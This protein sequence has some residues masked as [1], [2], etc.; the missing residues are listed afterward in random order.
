MTKVMPRGAPLLET[1]AGTDN[2]RIGL[3]VGAVAFGFFLAGGVLA[4]LMR[5][6]LAQPGLQVVS[7]SSYNALFTMHGSTMIYLFVTP[8][9]LAM[10]LYLVPLQVGASGVAGPRWA[11]AGMWLLV[12]GGITMWSGWLVQGGAA[13]ATWVGFD[14]LSDAVHSPGKAMDSWIWGVVLATLGELLMAA[15]ILATLLGRRAAGMTMLRMPVFCWA[16]LVTCLMVLFAFPVLIGVMIALW[17]DRQWGGV[18][19]SPGGPVTYQHL[20]WF[21]GHPVVYVMFFPFLG[22]VAEVIAVFSGRRIFGY[23]GIVISLLVFASLSMSVWAHHMFTVQGVTVKYFSLTS[24]LLVVP[25]GM[26]YFS[27]LGTLRGGAIRLTVPMLFALAFLLQFLVGGLSG[28]WVASPALDFHANNSY[29]VVAHFHYTLLAGSIFGFFAGVYYW[30][31]KVTGRLLGERL[32]RVHLAL[33]AIATNLTFAPQFALGEEGMTRRIA[34]YPRAAGWETLN[35]LSTLGS[36]LIAVSVLVFL[37]N[38]AV[39]RRLAGPDPWG[40]HTLEWATLSPPPRGNFEGELPP[41]RSHA[42]LLDR[43]P[44]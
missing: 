23:R 25:A 6:E 3:G 32:G 18:F 33:F 36:Y 43:V 10:G 35:S 34:D 16:E 41:I 28:I 15:S 31:P 7:L 40:G 42:P 5:T 19:T 12:L 9:A 38:A 4:I 27:L 11:L 8:V 21:Y 39:S 30:W 44:A 14:P 2:K 37:V 22:A 24:T 29:V 17:I 26:E 1:L 20:F 13:Q